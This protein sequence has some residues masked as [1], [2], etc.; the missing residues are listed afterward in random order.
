MPYSR[1]LIKLMECLKP[2]GQRV[3]CSLLYSVR[4]IRCRDSCPQM[5]AG[6]IGWQGV[7]DLQHRRCK[8]LF[9]GETVRCVR[10]ATPRCKGLFTGGLARCIISAIPRC[11]ELFT[12]ESERCIKFA[13][14]GMDFFVLQT[15]IYYTISL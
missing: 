7:S 4:Q 9:T 5:S 12:G 1:I 13:T 10:F 6:Q 8:E 14:L 15:L 2:K 11:K 3:L